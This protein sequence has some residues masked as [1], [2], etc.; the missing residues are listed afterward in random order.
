MI[1]IFDYGSGNLRSAERAFQSTGAKVIVTSDVKVAQNSRGLVIPG[2]GAFASCMNQLKSAGG[3][4]LIK[5]R[6]K[7]GDALLGICVGMQILFQ[8]SEEKGSHQGLGILEGKVERLRNKKLPQIGW[9]TVSEGSGSKL[10]KN[11]E[12]QSFYFVHSYAIKSD[13]QKAINSHTEYGENFIAA[14]EYENVS[15]TQFHPEKSGKM[16]LELIDNWVSSL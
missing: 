8:S 3:V 9:N 6:A 7:S 12:K 4:E 10:F 16:G 5:E 1:A 2:V 13:I 14:V 15:A 11:L